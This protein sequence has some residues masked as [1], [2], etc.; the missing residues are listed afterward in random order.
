MHTDVL[1]CKHNISKN[2]NV[3]IKKI[4]LA[5]LLYLD[6]VITIYIKFNNFINR[7]NLENYISR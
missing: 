2:S 1:V 7:S 6:L 4:T 3:S 5:H